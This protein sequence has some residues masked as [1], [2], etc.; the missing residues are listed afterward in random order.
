MAKTR[1]SRAGVTR[2]AWHAL[3]LAFAVLGPGL[4]LAQAPESY[5]GM[6][7]VPDRSNV[8]SETGADRLSAA[9]AGALPRVYVPHVTSSDVYVIDPATLKVINRFPVGRH[10]QHVVPS[11]DL[12]TLW[13]TNVGARRVPGS[14]TP[15]DPTTGQPGAPIKV[16]DPYNLYF[17]PG[18]QLR[19]RGRGGATAPRLPRSAHHG[20]ANSRCRRRNAAAS[21]TRISR[22]T[23]ATRSSP[24]SSAARW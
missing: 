4:A 18:R 3:C 21:I 14:V 7:P 10:A 22:S 20:A 1:S 17:T 9:V 12:K 8:Y 2:G 19:R 11:W 5:P 15:I 16:D 23:A 13:V 24:A 6:P